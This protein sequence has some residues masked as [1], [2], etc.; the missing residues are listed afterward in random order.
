MLSVTSS[1][2]QDNI[3][4]EQTPESAPSPPK[5]SNQTEATSWCVTPSFCTWKSS[6]TV[7]QGRRIV[8][9]I[10]WHGQLT[11]H[12]KR[13]FSTQR[14]LT[15]GRKTCESL[16][17]KG[18]PLSS[19]TRD[20]RTPLQCI[21]TDSLSQSVRPSAVANGPSTN[22]SIRDSG[23]TLQLMLTTAH[24]ASVTCPN[25]ATTKRLAWTPPISRT[26]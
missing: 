23:T 10:S 26:Q 3:S 20:N 19:S 17:I 7:R 9:R 1:W 6:L 25:T 8:Q 21:S 24:S 11:N 15:R 12:S 18:E 13:A 14:T 2:T 5:L 4:L 22:Q 16:T